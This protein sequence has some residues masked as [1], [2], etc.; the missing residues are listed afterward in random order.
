VKGSVADD[1]NAVEQGA[2]VHSWLA[3][4]DGDRKVRGHVSCA[5]ISNVKVKGQVG[6]TEGE[7]SKDQGTAC[8]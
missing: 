4:K 3:K 7:R 6:L 5:L 1:T 2:R 8:R